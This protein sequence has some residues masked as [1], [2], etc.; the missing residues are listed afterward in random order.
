MRNEEDYLEAIERNRKDDTTKICERCFRELDILKDSIAKGEFG[1]IYCVECE[2]EL[3]ALRLDEA[4]KEQLR[5]Q[6]KYEEK[7]REL[8]KRLNDREISIDEYLEL[9]EDLQDNEHSDIL[10]CYNDV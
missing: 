9:L 10:E 7:Y 5:V 3:F 2:D 4:Y 1:A 6:D 8:K